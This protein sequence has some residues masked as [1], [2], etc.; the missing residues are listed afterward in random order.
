MATIT[1]PAPMT[2][3]MMMEIHSIPS[4]L[5]KHCTFPKMVHFNNGT[6]VNKMQNRPLN[7]QTV[8]D[9]SQKFNLKKTGIQKALDALADAGKISFKELARIR[10]TRKK[11]TKKVACTFTSVYST[12]ILISNF[13][14]TGIK[15]RNRGTRH[16]TFPRLNIYMYSQVMYIPG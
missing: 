11:L 2:M 12:R 7:S 4:G 9:F 1:S 13:M 10:A 6:A 5:S 15:R 3:M 14:F 16:K 8:A